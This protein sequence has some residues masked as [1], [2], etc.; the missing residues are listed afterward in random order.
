M[1]GLPLP[2]RVTRRRAHKAK[3]QDIDPKA[4]AQ[5]PWQATVKMVKTCSGADYNDGRGLKTMWEHTEGKQ[6][7]RAAFWRQGSCTR[8]VMELRRNKM[9]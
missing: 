2:E 6:T 1:T 5:E 9:F 7:Q 8:I 4:A 3:Y